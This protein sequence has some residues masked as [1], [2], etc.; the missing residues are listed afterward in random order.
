MDP[1][2]MMDR[3]LNLVDLQ[4]VAENDIRI[5][6]LEEQ[7]IEKSATRYEIP[8][9]Y[10]DLC[11]RSISAVG[12]E[13]WLTAKKKR[14][15]DEENQFFADLA[16]QDSAA[17]SSPRKPSVFDDYID[18]TKDCDDSLDGISSASM[19]AAR[20]VTARTKRPSA[21]FLQ[22]NMAKDS[23]LSSTYM[24]RVNN[25]S[26]ASAAKFLDKH[27]AGNPADL[28]LAL[29]AVLAS[30]MDL[31]NY[32]DHEDIHNASDDDGLVGTVCK[33]DGRVSRSGAPSPAHD[34][35]QVR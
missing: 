15:L 25:Q 31:G 26:G 33:T 17:T 5:Q 12:E 30:R 35:G 32:C 11:N 28:E 19:V 27:D 10:C 16:S 14:D 8:S 29:T 3:A 34:K 2:L 18:N 1:C 6:K 22:D 9:G 24:G 13:T 20:P 4:G 21:R 7:C 23:S